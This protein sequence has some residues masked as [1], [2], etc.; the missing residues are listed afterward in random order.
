MISSVRRLKSSILDAFS[1]VVT[2]VVDSASSSVVSIRLGGGS[3]GQGSGFVCS[4]D[5]YLVTNSHVVADSGGTVDV[6]FAEESSTHKAEVVGMDVATD[7]AL[8]RMN[9]SRKLDFLNFGDSEQLKVGQLVTAIGN[10]LGFSSSVSAGVVSSLKRSIRSQ[11]GRLIDNVIQTD[12]AL[13]PGNSGGPLMN[14]DAEVIGVNT[15]IVA[16]AQGLSFAIPSKTVEWVVSQLV[17]YGKVN[18]GY[19]G[20]YGYTRPLPIE[21]QKSLNLKNTSVVVIQDVVKNGP[22]HKGGILPGDVAI[23]A[24]GLT[25]ASI[26]DLFRIISQK[27]PKTP[28]RVTVLREHRALDFTV[29]VGQQQELKPGI[30]SGGYNTDLP[31]W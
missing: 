24:D 9:S 5:G 18:R 14:S 16:G 29:I 19:L 8:L 25:I 13:N 12:V 22:A 21:I 11:S 15:A 17:R 7:I 6:Q 1:A 31:N 30:E 27:P 28:I 10:P 23:S 2:S 3:F 4:P 26:D 20:V